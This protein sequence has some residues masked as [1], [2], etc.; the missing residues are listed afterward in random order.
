MWV[1]SNPVG[2]VFGAGATARIGD[3]IAGRRWALITYDLP[4]FRSGA[5]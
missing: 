3:Q 5:R 1:Y 2:I 4:A